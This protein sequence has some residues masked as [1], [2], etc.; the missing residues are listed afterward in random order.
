ML[1]ELVVNFTR[2]G[3]DCVQDHYAYQFAVQHV[4]ALIYLKEDGE[5]NTSTLDV[6]FAFMQLKKEV[7]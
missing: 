6:V 1:P 2:N 4:D 3:A 7:N 5:Y